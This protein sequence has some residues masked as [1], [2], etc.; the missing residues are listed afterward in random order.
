MVKV[1]QRTSHPPALPQPGNAIGSLTDSDWYSFGSSVPVVRLTERV[2]IKQDV[3]SKVYCVYEKC[4]II[5]DVYICSESKLLLA[6]K[7]TRKRSVFSHW[8]FSSFSPYD[9]KGGGM[10]YL[11]RET[12]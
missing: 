7:K 11:V 6:N 3:S 2:S 1:L 5:A 12:A 10:I 9:G 8:D 4:R